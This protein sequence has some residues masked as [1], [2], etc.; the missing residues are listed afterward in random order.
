MAGSLRLA[1]E[2][3]D[4]IATELAE[5]VNQLGAHDQRSGELAPRVG[6][7]AYSLGVAL[8]M[9]PAAL[10][11]LYVAGVLHDI[12]KL[13]IAPAMLS[14]PGDL[15]DLQWEAM[16]SHVGGSELLSSHM[17][18]F[19]GPMVSGITDHHEY[20]GGRGYPHGEPNNAS[21]SPS[22]IIGV[23]SAYVA[24]INASPYRPA[25]SPSDA[26]T[27]LHEEAPGFWNPAVVS[28]LAGLVADN[29][30]PKVAKIKTAKPAQKFA[31]AAPSHLPGGG[32]KEKLAAAVAAFDGFRDTSVGR[33]V[34]PVVAVVICAVLVG[35]VLVQLDGGSKPQAR[36]TD[37]DPISGL[38]HVMGSTIVNDG[39]ISNGLGLAPSEFPTGTAHGGD[40]SSNNGGSS[41]GGLNDGVIAFGGTT[42]NSSS[43]SSSKS[44]TTTKNSSNTSTTKQSSS[45]TP[46][47]KKPT[48]PTTKKPTTPTTTKPT[49]PTTV[50]PSPPAGY[51]AVTMSGGCKVW[52]KHATTGSTGSYH[53][54]ASTW[55]RSS[56][57]CSRVKTQIILS[58]NGV[59]TTVTSARIGI[60]ASSNTN[61]ASV[62]GA[63]QLAFGVSLH[64]VRANNG[65]CQFIQ[66]NSNNTVEISTGTTYCP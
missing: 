66:L 12:G 15:D 32:I 19:L 5:L 39:S 16:K 48:T 45:T 6:D 54:S 49:T 59:N 30:S 53:S 33:V 18:E 62:S 23:A 56:D 29:K 38:E 36:E 51:I 65:T 27:E 20:Y 50:V 28:A 43:N 41:G 9:R 10:L 11:P 37:S 34:T 24:M 21:I 17:M 26:L 25:L 64:Y 58:N 3:P 44:N 47:T 35:G 61:A 60:G 22:Q 14:W 55:I 31:V 57:G 4:H 40:S 42:G 52:V 46:T 8:D 1:H 63:G 2:L 7:L 13:N